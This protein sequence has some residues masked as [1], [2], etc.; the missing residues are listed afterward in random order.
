MVI[1]AD[2]S[3][4]AYVLRIRSYLDFLWVVL[5]STGIFL[6]GL[7]LSEESRT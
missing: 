1:R 3:D 5:T 4:C 6:R 2:Y 7:K